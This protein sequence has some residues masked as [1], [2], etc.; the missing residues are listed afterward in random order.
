MLHWAANDNPFLFAASYSMLQLARKSR[1]KS[2]AINYI[3]GLSLLI[4]VFHENILLRTYVRPKIINY[5]YTHFGYD[6]IAL[7]TVCLALLIFVVFVLAAALYREVF[8]KY[9]KAASGILYERFRRCWLAVEQKL[10]SY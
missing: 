6:R 10:V 9:V 8:Q 5:I 4:Y 3:S 2:A 7:W 1:R